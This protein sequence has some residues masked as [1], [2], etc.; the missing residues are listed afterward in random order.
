MATREQDE[1]G[2]RKRMSTDTL[3][4]LFILMLVFLCMLLLAVTFTKIGSLERTLTVMQVQ[5][6]MR[7]PP[8]ERAYYEPPYAPLA[9]PPRSEI[10][11]PYA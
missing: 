3:I 6:S 2:A 5:A 8:L 7:P 9:P 1:C 10:F 4:L 11:N